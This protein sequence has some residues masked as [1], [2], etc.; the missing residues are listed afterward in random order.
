[1]VVSCYEL[2]I[3]SATI[4]AKL[5]SVQTTQSRDEGPHIWG[6]I[7]YLLTYLLMELSPS[8][9]AANCA[10]IQKIPSKF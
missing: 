10:A 7:T 6:S 4:Q 5:T 1:M 9:E 2:T 3:D 8:L